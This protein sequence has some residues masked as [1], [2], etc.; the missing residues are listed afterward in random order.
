VTWTGYDLVV[1]ALGHLYVEGGNLARYS[2][3]V[4]G[5]ALGSVVCSDSAL[6]A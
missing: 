5:L 3:P 4:G 2:E 6:N 1:P